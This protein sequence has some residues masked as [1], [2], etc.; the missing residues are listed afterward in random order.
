MPG[1]SYRYLI[2]KTAARDLNS[3]PPPVRERIGKKLKYFIESGDPLKFANK[4]TGMSDADYRFR[5]GVYRIVFILERN[6]I[7]IVRVQHRGK[8]YRNR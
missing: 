8:V 3:L 4:L 7:Y 2:T 5:V 1:Q 6:T